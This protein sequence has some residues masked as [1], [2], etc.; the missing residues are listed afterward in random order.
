MQFLGQ[1]PSVPIDVPNGH[2]RLSVKGHAGSLSLAFTA[3][4]RA[5]RT[6]LFGPS[7]CGKSTLLRAMCGLPTR[8]HVDFTRGTAHGTAPLVLDDAHHHRPPEHRQIAY[9]PQQAILFAHLTVR[10]NIAFAASVRPPAPA[11]KALIDEAIELFQLPPLLNRL[12]RALSGGEQQRVALARAYA[13][14]GAQLLLL[15]EPFTGLDRPL[16]DTLLPRLQAQLTARGLPT[17]AVT[18]DIE[19]A[20]LWNAEV[21]RLQDG[22]N[23]AQGP[24]ADVLSPEV[25][26]LRQ[27]LDNAALRPLIDPDLFL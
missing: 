10:E 22:R 9:A 2:H 5:P 4:F 24:A 27:T 13:M 6:V 21:I 18:H 17:V 25:L 1:I 7:G 15:D 14:P 19:E 26:R 3:D 12:P 23:L 11:G 16:R 20:L 8:L